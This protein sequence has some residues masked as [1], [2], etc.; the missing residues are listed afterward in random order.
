MTRTHS[1]IGDPRVQRAL[2]RLVSLREGDIAVVEAIRCGQAA[3]PQLRRLLFQREP[4][5][6]F[7]TRCRVIQ[8]LAALK[9]K[10]VLLEF[11]NRPNDP[12]D[13]VESLGDDAVTNAAA[14]AVARFREEEVFAM[15]LRL[16]SWRSLPGLIAALG[17]F[18]RR[19]A[20]P[21]LIEALSEDECRLFAEAALE[22]LGTE[23]RE[24]LSHAAVKLAHDASPSHLRQLRS[25]ECL[26][27]RLGSFKKHK[28]VN[29][30]GSEIA[31]Q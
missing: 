14:R 4:S 13:P 31:P 23:A 27:Q 7:E 5:G 12:R 19:E 16:S 17:T 8:V 3:V 30:S 11:L 2:D 22:R 20:I 25:V 21:V 6:L 15:L 24:Q 10:D 1:D 18:N 26:L 9:A 29:K 28:N